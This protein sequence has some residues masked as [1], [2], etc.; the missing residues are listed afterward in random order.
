[1]L[2]SWREYAKK[3]SLVVIVVDSSGSMQGDKLPSVQSTLNSYINS[4]GEKEKVAL[5]DF[6]AKIR[7]PV[8]VDGTPAGKERGIQFVSGLRAEGGTALYDATLYA[9][10]WLENSIKKMI[11]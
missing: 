11:Q 3:P 9:R 10:N 7:P 8:L 5:I 2:Q 1:M 6:D 4:L